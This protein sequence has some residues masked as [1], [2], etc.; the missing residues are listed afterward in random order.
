MTVPVWA[1]FMFIGTALF[2]Y[3]KL[4]PAGLPANIEPDAVFPHFIMTQLP[5]G[6]VGLIL[7][8]LLAAAISTLVSDL[9]C[10][11][12]VYVEDYHKRFVT[13]WKEKNQLFVS[14]LVILI[15]GIACM[16]IAIYYAKQNGEGALGLVFNLYSIFSGGIA[17]L[18]LLGIF[19]PKAN[20]QGVYIGIVACVLFTGWAV[21]TSTSIGQGEA[22]RLM[23]NF[24]Q[25]NYTHHKM[26]LGVYSHIVLFVVASVASFFF[27]TDKETAHLTYWGWRNELRESKK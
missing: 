17:G 10:L 2:A 12:A 11:S 23:L 1:L 3:Y 13:N 20:K 15:A 25:F 21:L 16:L 18:F 6:V 14:R 4:N 19:N 22:K 9:N 7:A 5:V 24:G 26:M 27:K 8:A